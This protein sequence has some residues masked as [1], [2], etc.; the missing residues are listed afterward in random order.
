MIS[1]PAMVLALNSTVHQRGAASP[2][3]R[4]KR[5]STTER[6]AL[7]ERENFR[8]H[9]CGGQIQPGQAWDVSHEI[10]LELGGA[11]DDEN[12]RA[13]HRKCHRNHTAKVDQPKI[14]K[15]K[16]NYAKYRGAAVSQRPMRGGRRD[17]LKRRMDGTVV[18]RATGKP[19]FSRR[20]SR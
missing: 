18:I 17:T 16:R 7:L 3:P 2:A 4:R 14:A 10:P 9:L 8:C 6:L 5:L 11:D 20:A 15:A 13:A 12:R 19:L 1:D